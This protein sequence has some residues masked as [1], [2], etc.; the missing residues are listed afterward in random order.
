MDFD[1][2]FYTNFYP[3]LS[4]FKT[5]TD[6]LKHYNN[7]GLSEGR[8]CNKLMLKEHQKKTNIQIKKEKMSKLKDIP[9]KC[10]H[11]LIRT[12]NR[13]VMFK[14]CM[15]CILEQDYSNYKIY[16][17][18]DNIKALNYL[19]KYKDYSNIKYFFVK[20]NNSEKYK[21]NLY[22]NILLSKVKAGYILFL[23]DDDKFTHKYALRILNE[24]LCKDGV[25]IWKF[26]RPDKLIYPKNLKDIKLGDIASSNFCGCKRMYKNM[27]WGDQQFGDWHFFSQ[28]FQK[29]NIKIKFMNKILTQTQFDNK[30]GN[31][32]IIKNNNNI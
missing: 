29:K 12:S 32:G 10:I 3:D 11:I 19:K 28:L 5:K 9:E 27:F 7:H 22:N 8:I 2:K 20:V 26:Y 6:A 18:Y 23:D 13:P 14:H 25:L 4:I 21:F 31:F 24:N 30:I 17:C 16:I 1:W 15:D